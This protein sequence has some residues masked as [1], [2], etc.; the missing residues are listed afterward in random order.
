MAEM[1]FPHTPIRGPYAETRFDHVVP[2]GPEGIR[3]PAYGLGWY[4]LDYCGHRVIYNTGAIEGFRS[5]I[6]ILPDD[7]FGLA[8]MGN[9]DNH[10][11]AV[12]L[13]QAIV[14]R[15]LG[16][17]DSDW[18]AAF[19][20]HELADREAAEAQERR[21]QSARLKESRPLRPLADYAGDYMDDGT[22]G[23]STISV[24]EDRL[25]LQAGP[26]IYD[27]HHWHLDVFEARKR[28]P[29]PLPRQFF[30]SFRLDESG[31]PV[32]LATTNDALFRRIA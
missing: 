11:L 14:D 31:R 8:V 21:L 20:T 22:Y 25:V 1:Y 26:L 7:D 16:I 6:G 23:R 30:S 24:A 18:S 4:I 9:S 5:V 3:F 2:L 28:W 29:Y 10:K 19:L 12:A 17:E 13:F 32:T 15:R 27:L